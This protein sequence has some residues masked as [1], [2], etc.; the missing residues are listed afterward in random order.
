MRRR[1]TSILA[2]SALVSSALWLV[3]GF[4]QTGLDRSVLPIREPKP[5]VITELDARKVKPPARF[6]VN[7]P[8][9]AP[10]V[11][12][13]LLDDYGYGASSTFG[14]PIPMPTAD[15]LATQ[16]LRYTRFH[17]TAM[18]APTRA[19]LLSGRNS[20]SVNMGTIAEM[21][22]AMPGYTAERPQ[23]IAPL[24]E[25]LKQ[26]GY[27]TAHFGKTHEVPTWDYSVV[28]S[29]KS[30]PTQSGMEVFYGFFGGEA[31]QW[32]PSNLYDGQTKVDPPTR[33]GYH[34]MTDMADRSIAYVRQQK[35]I[36]PDK[37]FFVYFAPGAT[38]APHQ[39]PKEWIAKFKGK[40][41]MGWDK[42]REQTLARQ[43]ELGIAPAGTKLAAK[44][45]DIQDWDKL[46]ADEKKLFARQMEVYAGYA[47][48]ADHEIGRL[49]D[50]VG[51]LGV[52]DNTLV[53]Y[54]LG[55]NGAS[56]EGRMHG[57]FNEMAIANGV[58]EPI[59]LQLKKLDELGGPTANNHYA[60]GWAVATDTP[61]KWVKQVASDYG[62]TRNG[63]VVSWPKGIKARGELRRQ[64]AHVI[65]LAPTVLDVASLPQPKEVNG[66]TQRPIEGVSM[67]Y[68]FDDANA[69]EQHTTQYFEINSNRGV[70]HD[71]WF[72]GATR[73]IPWV[74]KTPTT[75][76]EQDTWELYDETVDFSLANDLA[77]SNPGKLKEMQDAFM[78]EG[79][80]YHVLPIDPR[81]VERFNAEIA[82]RPEL[83]AGRTSMTLYESMS[84]PGPDALISTKNKSFTIVSNIEV[85]DGRPAEGVLLANGGLTGGW[86]LYVKSGKPAFEWNYVGQENYAV[87]SSAALTPGKHVVKYDF[88]YEGGK[89]FGK[90]GT[91]RLYIDDALVGEAKVPKTPAFAYSID[92]MDV[93]RDI[94]SRVSE[95][96]PEGDSNRFNGRIAKVF[97]ETK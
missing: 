78:T 53:Y 25:T 1:V 6:E 7:A 85:P 12:V 83:L 35:A 29:F 37:P 45:K 69:K 40:F 50:A 22:T 55:D 2:A 5:P 16:G 44:P 86:V 51:E 28:G 32:Q 76:L 38:H 91:S 14:G 46:S 61:Y 68:S 62:G 39:A 90:G 57:L 87:N 10:N 13:I 71:G 79:A 26:N 48:Y 94:A 74:P 75:P 31:D 47:N 56:G 41:D 9:G 66:F 60:A 65:D 93:G 64:F 58:E 11:L 34:F 96:Y 19:A 67:R 4:A 36:A 42:L 84:L 81:Y 17:T 23:D 72:A 20:H 52:L 49:V 73:L 89:E 95:A 92:G 3:P 59:E 63:L 82:G 30:W 97:I 21:A 54:I 15:R 88:A 43:I 8:K 80:K 18:C 77:A 70:Y 33:P 24:A 27:N